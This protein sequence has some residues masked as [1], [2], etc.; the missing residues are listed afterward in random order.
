MDDEAEE[1]PGRTGDRCTDVEYVDDDGILEDIAV[2][3]TMKN[4]GRR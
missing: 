2:V 4:D 3:E 1:I